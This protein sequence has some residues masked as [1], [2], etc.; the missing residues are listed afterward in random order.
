[1]EVVR[2]FLI[3]TLGFRLGSESQV[4]AGSHTYLHFLITL[5][6]LIAS[7][8]LS[9]LQVLEI[10]PCLIWMTERKWCP[11][12]MFSLSSR[13]RLFNSGGQTEELTLTFFSS[14]RSAISIHSDAEN[15]HTFD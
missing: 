9:V 1:M 3:H 2:V 7:G 10:F 15:Y 11:L 12:M 6:V 8:C 14:M 4:S 13:A 5:Q